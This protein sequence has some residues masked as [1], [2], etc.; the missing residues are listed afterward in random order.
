MARLLGS[1]FLVQVILG[2]EDTVQ[3][4]VAG[5]LGSGD[6]G[7]RQQNA[8]WRSSV[9]ERPQSVIAVVSGEAAGVTFLDLAKAAACAA[10]VLDPG[11]RLAVLSSAT[12]ALADGVALLRRYDNPRIAVKALAK[13]K[14]EDWAACYLWCYAANRAGSLYLASGLSDEVAEELFATPLKNVNEVQRLIDASERVLVIPDA[15]RAMVTL[16]PTR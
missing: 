6:E 13:R 3:S 5:L 16:E 8:R 4:V 2:G 10:R 15:H 11:G 14:P 9:S 1:P 12:P 7:I